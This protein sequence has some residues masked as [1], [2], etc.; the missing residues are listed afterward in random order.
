MNETPKRR[1]N[2]TRALLSGLTGGGVFFAAVGLAVGWPLFNVCMYALAAAMA[3][4]ASYLL[5]KGDK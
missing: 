5:P 1:L 4:L 2:R 3:A